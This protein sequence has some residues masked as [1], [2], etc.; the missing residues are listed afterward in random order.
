[1]FCHIA[2][3][4]RLE[5]MQNAYACENPHVSS[6]FFFSSLFPNFFSALFIGESAASSAWMIHA[7]QLRIMDIR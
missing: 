1:V 6:F 4:K 3:I 7:L 2:E 5:I